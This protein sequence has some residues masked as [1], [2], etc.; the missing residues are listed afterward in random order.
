MI[1]Y[2]GFAR[3][4]RAMTSPLSLVGEKSEWLVTTAVRP[5]TMPL[6]RPI[7]C[8]FTIHFAIRP[9]LKAPSSTS[10]GFGRKLC[11][12]SVPIATKDQSEL[13]TDTRRLYDHYII[14]QISKTAEVVDAG[15]EADQ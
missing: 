4:W 8:D 6:C 11:S 15:D 14:C 12:T 1:V 10:A 5:P 7:V 9:A 2:F 13:P 3:H